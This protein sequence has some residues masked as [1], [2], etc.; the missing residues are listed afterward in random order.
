MMNWKNVKAV[1]SK[2]IVGAIRDKRTLIAMI[3][4]PLIFYPLLFI[5]MGYFS[6]MGNKK[7]EENVSIVAIIGEEFALPLSEYIEKQDMINTVTTEENIFTRLKNG[8]VHAILE[9]PPQFDLSLIHISR[10]HET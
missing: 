8:E 2:E 9:I 6:Q 3:A 10:A 4:V 7:S 5:G 1:F